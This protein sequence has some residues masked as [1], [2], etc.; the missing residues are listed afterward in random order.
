M[1]KVTLYIEGPDRQHTVTLENELSIGRTDAAQII[2]NDPSLS[3]LHATIFREGDEV[4][5]LD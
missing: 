4:W 1:Q 2:L 5:I 3:R